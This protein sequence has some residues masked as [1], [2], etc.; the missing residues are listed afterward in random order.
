MET[1]EET[2]TYQQLT[3]EAKEKVKAWWYEHGLWHKWYEDSYEM[4][5]EKGY[6]LGFIIGRINFTG[7]YSQGDGACWSGQIDIVQWLKTHTSDSIAREA[8]CQLIQEGFT[9]KH[10]PIGFSGRYSHSG[11]MSIGYWEGALGGGYEL[12]EEGCRM[13]FD[14][15]FKGMY[16]TDLVD[17]ITSSDF[18]FKSMT[19]IAEAIEQSARDYADEIYKQLR[20]EY[21]YLTSE[22]NLIQSCEAN[23]WQFNNEGEMV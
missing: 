3:D 23:D 10:M 4:F 1:I 16:Y 5:T 18:E 11:T 20:E 7:F 12:D 2:F 13:T 21:D 15:I 14:S 6:D 17:I 19:D 8:W 9:E 22:E